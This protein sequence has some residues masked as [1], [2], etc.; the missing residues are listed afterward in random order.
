MTQSIII[1][2]AGPV[3]LSFAR[4]LIDTDIKVTIIERQSEE[5]LVDP[6]WDG[7]E[8]ALTHFSV[9]LMQENGSWGR[10]PDEGVSYIE[11]AEVLDGASPY[12]LSFDRH[13]ANKE[14]LGYLVPNHLIRKAIYQEVLDLPNVQIV[15]ATSVEKITTTKACG[16]VVLS[17]GDTLSADLIVASDSRFSETRRKMGIPAKMKDFGRT[18]IVAKVEHERSNQRMAFECFQYGRTMAVLPLKAH[19]SSIVITMA[20]DQAEAISSLSDKAFNQDLQKHFNN[21]FGQMQVTTKRISYPL[22]GVY[23]ERFYANR[24]AVIGD[25]A[26]GMHPVTAHGFNLGLR[27]QN[28]LYKEV[29]AAWTQGRD[30]GT[31][32]VL[33]AYNAN[34]QRV[35]RPLYYGTNGIVD[36]FTSET[37]PAKILRKALLRI[38]SNFSPLKRK[39]IDQ[40][41]I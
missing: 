11:R 16:T 7:R 6:Q 26:V 39:I 30:I 35:T 9:K 27:G 20:S 22:V 18:V 24:F 32:R 17:N 21:R 28:F 12:R 1:I 2:G 3:G 23:A 40:L 31:Y 8:I 4:S 25:A 33:T 10:L 41:T 38:G 19:E 5:S 36:V 34:H 29:K 14:T 13:E 15:Y 37:L